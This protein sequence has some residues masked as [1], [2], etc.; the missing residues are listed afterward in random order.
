M[1]RCILME[2]MKM[3]K[4]EFKYELDR[5]ESYCR[6]QEM[7]IREWE[8]ETGRV[9]AKEDPALAGKIRAIADANIAVLRHIASRSDR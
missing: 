2:E 4:S 7:S 5:I 9:V 1:D 6:L 8:K 3:G